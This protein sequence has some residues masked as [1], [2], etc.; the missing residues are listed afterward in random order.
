M[1]ITFGGHS[2]H[3]VDADDESKLLKL[4][5]EFNGE[6][7]TFY[8]GG[9]GSSYNLLQSREVLPYILYAF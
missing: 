5:D 1:V 9:Y 3:R 4:F 8:L 2:D 6:D 7:I